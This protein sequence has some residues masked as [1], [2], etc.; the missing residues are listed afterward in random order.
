VH[1]PLVE[2][3]EA[4][5]GKSAAEQAAGAMAKIRDR[6]DGVMPGERSAASVPSQVQQLIRDATSPE[7]LSTM[8]I[9]WMCW[10]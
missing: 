8:Y 1:D 3:E 7:Y 10:Y 2:F 9:W 4:R 5:G 6:L